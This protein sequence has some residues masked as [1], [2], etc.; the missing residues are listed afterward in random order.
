MPYTIGMMVFIVL[1][2][3][4]TTPPPDYRSSLETTLKAPIMAPSA[5]SNGQNG[6]SSTAGM[7]RY[8]VSSSEEAYRLEHEYSA[9]NY[10]PLPVV[11]AEAEGAWVTDVDGK[12]YLDFQSQLVNL[13]L[14]H[15]HPDI[16]NAIKRQAET[17]C[18][19]GPS[20]ANDARSELAA[21]VAEV[22]PGDLHSTFFTTGGAAAVENAVRLA[23]HVTGRQKV[24]ARY[25]S[26]HGA[27]AGSMTLTGDPR[28]WANEPGMP[29][30][31]HVLDPYHGVQRG[32]DDA[33]TALAMLEGLRWLGG[34]SSG[35]GSP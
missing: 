35:G 10:H 1:N 11:I 18:Y 31:V 8:H 7:S 15:Q 25:R 12:R 9:H 26:Y 27:T 13:N 6:H 33:A 5:V 4:P 21:L 23:R 22:T 20:M 3:D 14:G 24:L 28:R 16:V 17:L 34:R 32:W 2:P 29:G 30:V 19:I